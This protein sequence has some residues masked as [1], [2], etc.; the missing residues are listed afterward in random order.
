M[1]LL[2]FVTDGDLRRRTQRCYLPWGCQFV[3]WVLAAIIILGCGAVTVLYGIHFG[4]TKSILW[5]QSLFFAFLQCAFIT[6]PILVSEFFAA[7]FKAI[8]INR[9]D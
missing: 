3:A 1:W 8:A 2:L 9:Y 5:L 7:P 4:R 6:H